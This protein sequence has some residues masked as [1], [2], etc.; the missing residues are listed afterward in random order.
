VFPH[1]TVVKKVFRFDKS[2]VCL[3]GN[4]FVLVAGCSDGSVWMLKSEQLSG[5]EDSS[6]KQR[7]DE[8]SFCPIPV[9]RASSVFVNICPESDEP[10][11]SLIVTDR[12]VF[13][14][15]RGEIHLFDFG[16]VVR[17][18]VLA[19]GQPVQL[20]VGLCQSVV[21]KSLID[22]AAGSSIPDDQQAYY[23]VER[24]DGS[25]CL[26]T[27]KGSVCAPLCQ[28]PCKAVFLGLCRVAAKDSR[29]NAVLVVCESGA[30]YLWRENEK[31][32]E[33]HLGSAVA[34]CSV[35]NNV[36]VVC[37]LDALSP[38]LVFDLADERFVPR[39]MSA[40]TP[41]LRAVLA[42]TTK[43][44]LVS[45]FGMSG[46][47]SGVMVSRS[48]VAVS[49][50]AV[51]CRVADRVDSVRDAVQM[52][53]RQSVMSDELKEQHALA[54]ARLVEIN[55]AVRMLAT[56]KDKLVAN[57]ELCMND[58][59]SVSLKI[60]MRNGS[61]HYLSASWCVVVLFGNT[62]YSL[63]LLRG[64]K[65]GSLAVT[66]VP[67]V[68]FESYRAV[69]ARVW[70]VHAFFSAQT[71]NHKACVRFAE[72]RNLSLFLHSVTFNPW[73]L[74]WSPRTHATVR[75][76]AA[77]SPLSCCRIHSPIR[78]LIGDQQRSSFRIVLNSEYVDGAL[79]L[80][81]SFDSVFGTN[82]TVTIKPAQVAGLTELIVN[83]GTS[84]PEA[85]ALRAGM[86]RRFIARIPEAARSKPSHNDWR[87]YR[88]QLTSL[89]NRLENVSI[90]E[91]PELY[92][93]LRRL[94]ASIL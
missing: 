2:I 56:A 16:V 48:F 54:N 79:V 20:A 49:Q 1:L 65:K 8:P 82:V 55:Q 52:I 94:P 75:T 89:L 22:A 11:S 86:V 81:G 59:G 63:P 12:E 4:S 88:N 66:A 26:L 39:M 13:V 57:S 30:A 47:L 33:M 44:G 45:V 60:A 40:D 83:V 15:L 18:R 5:V 46:V 72:E 27:E 24:I 6:K 34:S 80:A 35:T 73:D 70:L 71:S 53:A 19:Q 43:A 90:H 32:K 58:D 77:K 28:L 93:E 91:L 68:T 3:S 42:T 17:S 7:I 85:F 21:P 51:A 92:A 84:S 61:E 37:P 31:V 9:K 29:D 64:L 67:N 23:L 74:C 50:L 69:E 25:V 87:N 38:P 76:R 14:C 62:V 10:P 78:S 41:A 36:L